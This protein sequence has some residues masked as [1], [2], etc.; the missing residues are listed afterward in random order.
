MGI[1]RC[2]IKN[3]SSNEERCHLKLISIGF[4]VSF[5]IP[6]FALLILRADLFSGDHIFS[7]GFA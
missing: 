2:N 4:A 7:Y 6:Y 1:K 5:H 3:I